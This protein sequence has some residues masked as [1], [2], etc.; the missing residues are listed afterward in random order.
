VGKFI[1]DEAHIEAEV[2][3]NENRQN[4][5]DRK[6]ENK[7]DEVENNVVDI[8]KSDVDG[9]NIVG[10]GIDSNSDSESES[11]IIL[12]TQPAQIKATKS[13][14]RNRRRKFGKN[15]LSNQGASS[16][17]SFP[18]SSGENVSL[19]PEGTFSVEE[20]PF[21]FPKPNLAKIFRNQS[22]FNLPKEFTRCGCSHSTCLFVTQTLLK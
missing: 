22:E 10:N 14:K 4:S 8:V 5:V 3:E 1:L 12:P 17:S 21:K 16:F 15:S 2:G 6:A 11:S 13:G 7:N 20:F 18:E 9:L 19:S